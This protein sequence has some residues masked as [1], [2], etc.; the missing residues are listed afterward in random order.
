MSKLSIVA[1]DVT[2]QIDAKL[3]RSCPEAGYRLDQ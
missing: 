1:W 3:A 2:M